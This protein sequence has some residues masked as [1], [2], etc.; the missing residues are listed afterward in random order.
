MKIRTLI[1]AVLPLMLAACGGAN[2][3]DQDQNQINEEA[4]ILIPQPAFEPSDEQDQPLLA[5]Y[6]FTIPGFTENTELPKSSAQTKAIDA[7]YTPPCTVINAGVKYTLSGTVSGQWY[8]YNIQTIYANPVK[9]IAKIYNQPTGSDHNMYVLQWDVTSQTH[10]LVGSSTLSGNSN[11]VANAISDSGH[12]V[13]YIQTVQS[14]GQ[15]FNISFE[16][17]SSYDSHELNDVGGDAASI[18]PATPVIGNLDNFSDID[19]F[20]YHTGSTESAIDVYANLLINHIM[21]ININGVWTEFSTSE[22][23]NGP[24][25]NTYSVPTNSDIQIAITQRDN[26]NLNTGN[27]SFVVQKNNPVNNLTNHTVLSYNPNTGNYFNQ[28]MPFF[29]KKNLGQLANG[30]Y[31]KIR[32]LGRLSGSNGYAKFKKLKFN[33]S[34]GTPYYLSDNFEEI[35]FTN[36]DGWFFIDSNLITDSRFQCRSRNTKLYTGYSYPT[37]DTRFDYDADTYSIAAVGLNGLYHTYVDNEN[38]FWLCYTSAPNN[39]TYWN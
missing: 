5:D 39:Y 38:I 20:T 21:F 29:Y 33:Y 35:V 27:Y 18:V 1:V 12:Y 7:S 9:V 15:P 34:R 28:T 37:P 6:P 26:Q 25:E 23:P 30:A 4:R 14:S 11:E 24:N 10:V 2:H 32:F 36:E 8:C 16:A 19:F 3:P 31:S 17:T 22:N 13:I